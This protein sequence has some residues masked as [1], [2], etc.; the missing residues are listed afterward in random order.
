MAASPKEFKN[1]LDRGAPA[2]LGVS[3]VA[4][5]LHP[6]VPLTQLMQ[7]R[8]IAPLEEFN[9]KLDE[10]NL[11][12]YW[13]IPRREA[14]EPRS[15]FEPCMW[16]WDDVY[17]ALNEAGEVLGLDESLRRFIAFRSPSK[18][19]TTHTI[20]LGVQLVKPREIARA[21]RHT[22]GAIRFVLKGGGAQTTIEGEPFPMQTGDLITTPSRTWHDHYNG[23]QEPIIW[24][25]GTDAPL[26]GLLEIGFAELFQSAQQPISRPSALS[27]YELGAARPSWVPQ[28]GQRPPPYRY[29]WE[30]TEKA[31]RMLGENPG[32]PFDG[33]LLRYVNPLTG[34]PTL[35]TFSCEIQMLRP[36]EVTKSHRHT[37]TAIYHVF[38]GSGFT[39]IGDTRFEWAKGD[40]FTV[41]LWRAHHHDNNSREEA[42]LFSTNDRPLMEALGFY[43]EEA[44]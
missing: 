43:R 9:R 35:P 24:L 4:K 15:S 40:S 21:H 31:F 13:G 1:Y 19:R 41:P 29:R 23:S 26:I 38:R 8:H 5:D 3:E 2:S 30:D 27:I 18:L 10:L 37:S 28:G 39:V 6:R 33:L 22:M 12:G 36:S 25:D 44:A 20:A 16:R 42:I 34:G 32:D 11:I 17:C 7:V 14:F